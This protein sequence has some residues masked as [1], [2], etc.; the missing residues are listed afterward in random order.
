MYFFYKNLIAGGALTVLVYGVGMTLVLTIMGMI[1]GTIVGAVLCGLSRSQFRGARIISGVYRSVVGGIPMLLFLLFFYYVVFAPF[2]IDALV[3][4]VVA[5]GLKTGVTVGNL[6]NAALASVDSAQVKAART[7]G[8]SGRGAFF[9]I[10][11][12]QAV[13]FGRDLYR[14]AMLELLQVTTLASYITIAELMR[15][16][17]S[18]Q[19]R[20]GQPF[21]SMAIGMLLY[22][23]LAAGITMVFWG[24]RGRK[25]GRAP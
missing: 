22:L 7:L 19:A 23:V 12:P 3:T 8:F 16:I 20:T 14:D 24:T 9:N 5:M 2:R 10:T 13:S 15:V 1:G 17:N 11:L 18:M 21:I 6:M 4:A 25:K